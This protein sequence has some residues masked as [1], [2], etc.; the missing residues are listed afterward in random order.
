MHL[1]PHTRL[2]PYE[3]NSLL[4]TGGTGAVYKATD[5]RLNRNVA[6]KCLT[7]PDI[8]RLER[9]AQVIAAMNHPYICSI[10]DVGEDYLVMEYVEGTP[11]RGPLP[12]HECLNLAGQIATALEAA[13]S[14]GVVHRDL[15]PANILVSHGT[16]KL[17]D[18]GHAKQLSSSPTDEDP[19]T[20]AGTVLGTA[21]YMSPEQVQGKSVDARSDVFSFGVVLY[22][23]V[24]G[25]RAFAG[26]AV[27]DILNA[28]VY[29]EPRP[30]EATSELQSVVMRC[31]NKDPAKRFQSMAEVKE[32]LARVQLHKPKKA[33]SI[34][35]LPFAN[36]SGDREN[37]YFCEGLTEEII[38]QLAQIP[39]LRV[40]ARTSVFVFQKKTE[41]IRKIAERL[42]VQTVLEGSVR[43]SGTR[44]RITAQLINAADGYHLW[45]KS[46]DRE[47]AEVFEIQDDI[48]GAIA[49]SL[50]VRLYHGSTIS[51]PAYEA[52]LKARH[53]LW[54]LTPEGLAQSREYYE[55][56]IA[57]DP[58]FAL[59]HS[60]YADYFLAR[61]ILGM[62]P[63]DE[64]MPAARMSARRAL[65]IDASLPDAHAVLAAVAT[66]F[67][68]DIPEAER[69]FDLAIAHEAVS[70]AARVLHAFYYLVP[71][72]RAT[73]AVKEL[74]QSLRDDPLNGT[75]HRVLGVCLLETGRAGDAS[76]E[77][78]EALELDEHS[79]QTMT[80]LA[81]EYWMRGLREE[82]LAWAERAYSL[83][84]WNSMPIGVYSGMLARSDE[85]ARARRVIEKLGD[86]QAYGAPLGLAAFDAL[87]GEIDGAMD[88]L[89]KLIEQR[90]VAGAYSL[91]YSPLGKD[92][93]SSDRWPALARMLHLPGKM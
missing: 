40:T 19:E 81:L 13:H 66:L 26:D 58:D 8:D 20:L 82:A 22:E 85:A 71:R 72:G 83:T 57:L 54:K 76:R 35:V 75:L 3:I 45:S 43:E 38:N 86:G 73:D 12:L 79:V 70:S 25:K 6:I 65:D 68:F 28:V 2:G 93:M 30:L 37:E 92:L 60:G 14:R 24:S 69:R 64:A 91:L 44:L 52:Y 11:I 10:Y 47:K 87:V 9:E 48:A 63:A 78:H 31:L 27:L 34:A 18:F 15:K 61:A 33:P 90:H 74:E 89:D 17:L 7:G 49:R 1:S 77:F 39:G 41:D 67:D 36:V 46:Y 42:D 23:L 21:A 16:V 29:D 84:P 80:M 51:I 5:T 32:A 55:Q 4:G 50:Q 88:W 53:Y 56:A 59:A 62:I